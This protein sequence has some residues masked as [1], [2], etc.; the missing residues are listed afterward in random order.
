L[1]WVP[2]FDSIQSKSEQLVTTIVVTSRIAHRAIRPQEKSF[3]RWSGTRKTEVALHYSCEYPVA[4]E[5]LGL[6]V[7]LFSGAA[8]AE[9]PRPKRWD[10]VGTN[11]SFA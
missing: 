1:P 6:V 5:R 9:N 7:K 3:M 4:N 2:G 10:Q 8:S 11:P